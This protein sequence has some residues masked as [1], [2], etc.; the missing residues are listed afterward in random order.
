MSEQ[1][2]CPTLLAE[3]IILQ[4]V[5]LEDA[6]DFFEMWTTDGFDV[7]GGF[8]KPSS[9]NAA[10][11][12]IEYFKTLN[13]SGFYFKWSIR[14][15]ETNEFLGE[16]ESYPLKP[17]IRP[18]IEWGL[19]Y[20]LKKSAWGNGYMTEA[21]NRFLLFAFEETCIVR[22]KADVHASNLRS[23]HLLNK[24]GFLREGIQ[25]SKNFSNGKFNDM[26]LMAY[27]R[28]RFIRER[29]FEY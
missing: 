7:S 19:G 8:E 15:R 3:R 2:S 20:S 4:P 23:I 28:E 29:N 13:A 27:A 25:V 11:D 22:L 17:Q 16:F 18:W 10:T 1:L 26:M 12:S 5:E 6:D 21:L 14:S 24:V 9:R